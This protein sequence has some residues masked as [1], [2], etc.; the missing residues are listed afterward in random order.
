MAKKKAPAQESAKVSPA[1]KVEAP[2][3]IPPKAAT[4]AETPP[5][6]PLEPVEPAAPPKP[7]AIK[8]SQAV[9]PAPVAPAPA[10]APVKP[11]PA[12]VAEP[13]TPTPA[14]VAAPAKAKEE[15]PASKPK[16]A[17][18]PAAK[19]ATAPASAVV[20][21]VIAKYDAGYGNSLHIRGNC[22]GLN[23]ESGVLMKNVE[24]D[25][26]VWTTNEALN[27]AVEFKLLRNDQDW[28]EGENMSAP[29]GET[30]TVV[31]TF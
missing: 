4:K 15:K 1:V 30:T 27:D 25:V 29:A 19:S 7:A 28:C 20:T 13:A 17:V 21:V 22:A 16:V 5:A 11:A 14:K 24:N 23:W 18:K 26:W 2:K 8:P 6:K 10:A 31:P 12:K 3:P 9:Q